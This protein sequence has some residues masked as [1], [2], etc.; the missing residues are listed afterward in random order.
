MPKF[1]FR[2]MKIE[3]LKSNRIENPLEMNKQGSANN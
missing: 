1:E 3:L 2:K